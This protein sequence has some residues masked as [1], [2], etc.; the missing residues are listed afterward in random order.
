[1]S[2]LANAVNESRS[3]PLLH[4]PKASPNVTRATSL[5]PTRGIIASATT[6]H[7]FHALCTTC[8]ASMLLHAIENDVLVGWAALVLC[9]TFLEGS[10]RGSE[11]KCMLAVVFVL[12]SFPPCLDLVVFGL[13]TSRYRI[14]LLPGKHRAPKILLCTVNSLPLL[15]SLSKQVFL[16]KTSLSLRLHFSFQL[17]DMVA[18]RFTEIMDVDH[19]MTCPEFNASLEDILAETEA[20]CRPASSD[21]ERSVRFMI[22][23]I[24]TATSAPRRK[25]RKRMPAKRARTA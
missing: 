22:P 5:Q 25:L 11:R 3:H 2:W 12:C 13:S 1:M 17:L 14:D 23:S 9:L 10:T 6:S 7:L 19:V 15:G 8:V 21:S 24:S 20:F 18:S 4:S 16:I